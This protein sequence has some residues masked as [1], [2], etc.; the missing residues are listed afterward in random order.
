MV[1]E[2]LAGRTA[3]L[4]P[5]ELAM[6]C[7]A[8]KLTRTPESAQE[9]D[10]DALRVAGLTDREIHDVTQVV[11]YFAYVNRIVLGLGGELEHGAGVIGHWPDVPAD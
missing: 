1:D 11:A 4:T 2:L 6:V 10:V 5:R 9:D 7:Y 3:H 8:D